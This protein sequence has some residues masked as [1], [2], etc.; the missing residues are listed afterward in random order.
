MAAQIRWTYQATESQLFGK[1]STLR[2]VRR[3]LDSGSKSRDKSAIWKK[4]SRHK[5]CKYQMPTSSNQLNAPNVTV[6]KSQPTNSLHA[7]IH[8]K[9]SPRR[10]RSEDLIWCRYKDWT[11]EINNLLFFWAA[12]VDSR[13]V[14]LFPCS[15]AGGMKN[16]STQPIKPNT[17]HAKISQEKK[18]G[19]IMGSP[20]KPIQSMN[21]GSKWSSRSST[22]S[23]A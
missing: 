23:S 22:N 9:L 2:S 4:E 12:L 10:T 17:Q 13:Q 3:G 16:T 21:E 11:G 8:F 7:A 5:Y 18:K 19:M 6:M 1:R 14:G 15:L 20:N